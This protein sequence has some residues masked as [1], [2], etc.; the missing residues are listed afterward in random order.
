M[1]K[2]LL[3][4]FL[5]AVFAV[6]RAQNYLPI[7]VLGYTM[8]AVAEN[9]PAATYTDAAIDGSNYVL[10]SASY[11]N[12]YSTGTGLP[13]NGI[14]TTGTR[15]YQM[16]PYDVKNTMYLPGGATDSFMLVTPAAYA[17]IS[18]LDLATEGSSTNT[19]VLEF[20]DGSSHSYNSINI[21][22]WFNG[23]GA[24]YSGF[25]RTGRT[26]D[27]PD[28]LSGEPNMYTTDLPIACA[29]RGKLLKTIII[30]NNSAGAR[31]CFF[32][33]SGVALPTLSTAVT[34]VSCHNGN[35][36]KAFINVTDGLSPFTYLWSSGQTTDSATGLHAGNYT[37]TIT[38]ANSCTL[39]A[40]DTVLQPSAISL[41]LT[42]THD[43]VCPLSQVSLHAH[44]AASYAWSANS[45]TDSLLVVAPAGNTIYS[46]TG[47]TN[48]CSVSDSISIR[49][50]S[51]NPVSATVSPADTVCAGTSITLSGTGAVTYGWTGDILN[52][53]PFV[54]DATNT[55]NVVGTDTNGCNAAG[56]IT[57][58]VDTIPVVT[59]V[60]NPRDTICQGFGVTLN[61]NGASTYAWSNSAVNG[62]PVTPQHTTTYTL[63]GTAS[64]GCSASA[65]VTITV[66]PAPLVAMS[67]SPPTDSICAGTAIT[68]TGY[69]ASTYSFSGGVSNGVAFTPA[70]SATYVL[71]GTDSVGCSSNDSIHITVNNCLGINEPTPGLSTAIY[72][73][74]NN[75]NFLLVLNNSTG[76]VYIAISDLQGRLIYSYTESNTATSYSKQIELGSVATGIYVAQV[77]AGNETYV[78]KISVQR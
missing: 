44:G 48:G 18:L 65:A 40:T 8:D 23:T 73:N 27:N 72:P 70:I 16:Q 64:T 55:Y 61:G 31:S 69:G 30:T 39:T 3:P 54:P 71:T 46:V 77:K 7:N 9:S 17:T 42:A 41:T 33:I 75:G 57:V 34:A 4:A 2:I 20:T 5:V 76:N 24:I 13:D 21:N 12:I 49:V 32:A 59:A 26:T 22:D 6:T 29:D 56:S 10:Y 53:Q 25:D 43:T 68:L 11:G 78:Q 19:I 63:T 45:S 58:Y 66:L 15:T 28:Y 50:Y 1:K 52:G 51:V 36:G 74:P 35:N 14:I 47:T 60:A 37:V 67:I 62:Q 38:D